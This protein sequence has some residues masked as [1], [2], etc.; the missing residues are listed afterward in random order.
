MTSLTSLVTEA[1]AT[2]L[3]GGKSGRRWSFRLQFR[4]QDYL[5]AFRELAEEQGLSIRVQ[6][7]YRS[8]PPERPTLVT[9]RQREALLLAFRRGYFDVPRSATVSE[10]ATELGI[11]D[12]ALSQRLRRGTSALVADTLEDL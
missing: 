4:D 11:S 7:V 2:L 3:H 5:A 1:K 8:D 6:S 10:L 9:P 12:N